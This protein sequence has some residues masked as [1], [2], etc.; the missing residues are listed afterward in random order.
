LRP[1]PH[2]VLGVAAALGLLIEAVLVESDSVVW[3]MPA[4][5]V[6]V[7]AL[8]YTW[9]EQVRLRLL[10]VC[11]VAVLFHLGL[12]AVHELSGS[13]GDQDP[14]GYSGYGNAL[15]DGSYPHAEYPLG[16]VLLFGLEAFLGGGSAE[17]PNQLVMVLFQLLCVV[18]IWSLRTPYSSWFAALV[19]I[20][21]LSTYFW[22][23]RFD[24]VPTA[25]IV[26]GLLLA[27]RGRWGWSG[28]AF[29]AGTAVKWFP[30]LSFAVLAVWLV[31]SAK[32]RELV[33]MTAAFGAVLVL[34]HAPFLVWDADGL[35]SAY[36]TQ[37]GRPIINR[38]I[39]SFP[40]EFAG[41]TNDDPRHWVPAGGP[42]WADVL[43]TI[44][45]SVVLVAL[46]LAAGLVSG[47][48]PQAL[49]LAAAAPVVFLLVNRIFSS[50]FLLVVVAG[51]AL[52]GALVVASRREQLLLGFLLMAASFTNAFV[53]PYTVESWRAFAAVSF[54]AAFAAL[55]VVLAR[56]LQPNPGVAEVR[57]RP[58]A[59]YGADRDT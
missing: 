5:A 51:L 52:A 48:L 3:L 4:A 54:V 37:G 18:A 22:Q 32:P 43:A 59:D 39:W 45:Q 38:S 47:R 7:A 53:Y 17:G 6:G 28:V 34:V 15:L 41:L 10:P 13:G 29:A 19:A 30:A 24:L 46:F 35:L 27:R 44:L 16:A 57:G 49:A 12:V 11:A 21:P 31:T 26:V 40:L 9:L 33:R 1:S 23:Y 58:P 36:T 50:Q 56:A 42:R 25:L 14:V 8:G 20:W 2:V 55:A